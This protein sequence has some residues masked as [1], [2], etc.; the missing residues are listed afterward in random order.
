MDDRASDRWRSWTTRDRFR[1]EARAASGASAEF[2][3]PFAQVEGDRLEDIRLAAVEQRVEAD[4]ALG[5]EAD[6]IGEL[7][8]LIAENPT[9]E[10][11]RVQLMLALYRSDRQAEALDATEAPAARSTSSG[12]NRVPR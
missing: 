7:E 3:E 4:L 8:A 10:R 1:W 11:L 9:R 6:L 2:D 12:S 5:G